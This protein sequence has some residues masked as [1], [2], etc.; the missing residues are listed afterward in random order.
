MKNILRE[1]FTDLLDFLLPRY[2][3]VCG[4]R[5]S[6][7]ERHLCVNCLS[8]LHLTHFHEKDPNPVEQLFWG[9]IPIEKATSLFYYDGE[10]HRKILHALKYHDD[11]ELGEYL[12]EM[13]AHEALAEGFFE[14]VDVIVPVP[15]HWRKSLK[16]GY[17]QSVYFAR[18]IQR[19]THLPIDTKAVRRIKN[20]K[21]QTLLPHHA[22]RWENVEGVFQLSR[23]NRLH[24]KHVLLVDDVLTTGATSISCAKTIMEAGDMTFSV[25]SIA[26]AGR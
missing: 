25:M 8:Q 20:T 14:G 24:G 5:L 22:Q 12:G 4:E 7:L 13:L 6:K 18:G 21:T 3:R 17:N 10:G 11:A 2:C 9:K 16:R 19:V 1:S 26:Y 15:L 23:H